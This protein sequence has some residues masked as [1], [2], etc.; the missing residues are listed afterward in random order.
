M[1][2]RL[3]MFLASLFLCVGAALAQVQVKGTIISADDG[4]PLPGA[5]V[6]IVGE[7]TGTVTNIN[8]DFVITVPSNDTRL[9]ISHIG[10]V[11]RVVKARNG[12]RISLDTDNRM[13]DEVMVTAF[14]QQTKTS[15]TGSAVVVNAEDLNKK[16]TTNVA[17]ALVGAVP[18]LQIRGSSGA[19]GAGSG[20]INIRGI[21]SMFA[22]TEP[23]I[24]V[25]GAPYSASLSNIPQQ[26]IESVTVLKD[27]TSAALYGARGAGGVI[28]ITTKKGKSQKA[29]INV[30]MKWGASHRAIQE[31]D[32]IKDPAEYYET[33][34][35]QFY[36]YAFNGN[37]LSA[38][39]ANTW[40]NN[41]MIDGSTYGLGYNVYTLP[42][43]EGLIG[44]DGKLNPNATL[45]RQYKASNGETYF[46]TPDDWTK[47]AYKTGFRQEYNVNISGGENRSNYYLSAGYLNE[48]GIIDNSNFER[49]TARARA[50]YSVRDWL[51]IGANIGFVHSN[52]ES[53]PNLSSSSLGSTNMWYYT[54][55]IAP[56]YPLYV[57]VIDANG[58]P[59]IR[60]DENGHK[61]YDYGV[62][63]TG[64]VDLGNRLFMSTGNPIG[65]NMY[66]VAKSQGNQI[67]QIYTIDVDITSWLK[68]NSTNNLNLGQSS[69]SDYQNP[70]YG[71]SA[72]EGG[73]L[74]KSQSN[75]FRQ[76]YIQT[77][78]FHK[79]FGKH[80]TDLTLG[81]QYYQSHTKY[82]AAEAK[83]GFTPEIQEINAFAVRDN[84]S[85]YNSTYR[86]E[87]WF[88]N[89]LY[90]F[91]QK[92]FANASFTHEASSPSF[93]PDHWGSNFW[94]VGAGWLINKENFFKNLGASWVDQLKLKIAIGQ[95]GNDGIGS[96]SY[97]DTYSLAKNGTT[98]SP[99]FR[100]MENPNITWETTTNF[101]LGLEWSLWNGRVV[102][103]IDFYNKRIND[104]LFWVN[105]P[106]SNG[107]RGYYTNIGDMRNRGVELTLGVDVIR[108]KDI[109]WNITG[110]LSH[111]TTN[112]IS[113][114][115]QKKEKFGGFSQSTGARVFSMWYEEGKSLYN[116]FMPEY[117]G[118]NEQ[119]QAL[120]YYD[121]ACVDEDG[122]PTQSKPALSRDNT[123]TDFNS[124]SYYEQGSIL[125]KVTGGFATTLELYG[126]DI[127]ATFDYQIGGKVFDSRYQSLMGNSTSD[128]N[129]GA[130]YHKDILKAWTP[131][132]TESDIP[133][134]QYNDQFSTSTSTRFLTKAS[135]LNF[136]SFAVGYTL[137]KN[138]TQKIQVN[139]LRV[140]VQGENL[141]FWSARKG[142]D[143][144]YSF[145]TTSSMSVY[146][147]VRT[148]MGGVQVSF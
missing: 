85:S 143:P 29:E 102:G 123:T 88:A 80:D 49:F 64:Y 54:S 73:H 59:V 65:A 47:A 61:Q 6:K 19:P 71:P 38:Q 81:H 28:L 77:L 74:I 129:T 2:K 3:S 41:N 97:V 16:I 5:S 84:S 23:L 30:D 53:N 25:D 27:A 83:G 125:P 148:I 35:K 7:K 11:P 78:N 22:D 124:A 43:G 116:A 112:I 45:G 32:V 108:T 44:L 139:K 9:E 66:N 31:Y 127:S 128:S 37:G 86:D 72:G 33:Y 20:A 119:G 4:E 101:N 58:Q 51:R 60:T 62:P 17:D 70:W 36:N 111:N 12:M 82:L 132:N 114:P 110:N 10:M 130:T 42:E 134:F 141:C 140:Y 126:V 120:Y 89:A 95:Q 104:L 79:L 8:G 117:A 96:W 15:F 57:R 21:S 14:G 135:Y 55:N 142:L 52:T 131:N 75:T 63:A 68:F 103:N 99:I 115:D 34:Y 46:L 50:N 40:V 109:K 92:Y 118:V 122:A 138:L 144:R 24:I 145:D 146:S 69:G 67:N 76:T 121:P 48:D 18:G 87:L 147:P 93:S 98:M 56:I 136:Q 90:N 133:R 13:L 113:L 100:Q 107:T 39:A 26:D 106:E 137:P 91:N 94:S 1:E 105:I